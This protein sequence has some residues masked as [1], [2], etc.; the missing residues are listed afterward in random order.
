MEF[1][2]NLRDLRRV[3]ESLV[4]EVDTICLR[5]FSRYHQTILIFVHD[6]LRQLACKTS[7]ALPLHYGKRVTNVCFVLV[8]LT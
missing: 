8:L 1:S 3:K 7:V 4:V 2:E 5:E 6:K